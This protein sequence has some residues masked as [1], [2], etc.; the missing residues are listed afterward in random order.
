MVAEKSLS[1]NRAI[2]PTRTQQLRVYIVHLREI[3]EGSISYG[4]KSLL[5]CVWQVDAMLQLL[6]LKHNCY[7]A[8][9]RYAHSSCLSWLSLVTGQ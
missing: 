7:L 8:Y 6:L 2:C 9:K 5:R 1:W 4:A 3:V